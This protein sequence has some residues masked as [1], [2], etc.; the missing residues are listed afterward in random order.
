M[1]TD[2]DERLI[3]HIRGKT[4]SADVKKCRRGDN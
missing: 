3:D 1:Q 2:R 4:T